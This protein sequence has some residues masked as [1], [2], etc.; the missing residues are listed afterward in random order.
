MNYLCRPDGVRFWN[1]LTVSEQKKDP[2]EGHRQRLRNKFLDHGLEKLTDE[3]VL[4]LLLSFGTPRRDCKQAARALLKK[5][6]S[7]R[8]VF[9]AQTPELLE[10][11]GVGPNN[12]V[13][14]KL[15]HAVSGKFLEQR[16]TGRVY[17]NSSEQI[18][19]YL[20]HDLES[21]DKEVFKVIY[22]DHD[23]VIIKIEDL[24]HGSLTQTYVH[25]RELL[26]RA[27]AL[28]STCLVFV[29]NHPTGNVRPSEEDVKLTR[30][31]VH[32]AFLVEMMVLDHIIIGK[33]GE[34]YSFKDEGVLKIFE[35]E[36]RHTY[37]MPPRPS[38]GLLHESNPL[39]DTPARIKLRR[40]SPTT[41]APDRPLGR[42][43]SSLG[44]MM[45]AEKEPSPPSKPDQS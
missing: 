34:Y 32:A 16:L 44:Q 7:I 14:I 41:P 24:S 30:R 20:R 15:I 13:A 6:G 25:T 36:I 31:L 2:R 35:Q 39:F 1:G 5:F 37:N 9:E 33:G 40:K 29:H 12:I 43:D 10:I 11:M 26:E 17:L 22:L 3:E 4:E 21:Q 45:V 23:N 28:K 19:E 18:I 27:A 42:L 8:D 38:G